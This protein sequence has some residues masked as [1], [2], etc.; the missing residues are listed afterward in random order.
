MENI[1]KKEKIMTVKQIFEKYLRAVNEPLEEVNK[2]VVARTKDQ[3]IRLEQMNQPLDFSQFPN[4]GSSTLKKNGIMRVKDLVSMEMREVLL[5]RN[6]GKKSF[7]SMNKYV[8]EVLNLQWGMD[9][10]EYI[11]TGNKVEKE[12]EG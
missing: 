2:K 8:T 11:L 1:K 5:L 10:D 6:I 3:K 7:T 4:V 12:R 9:T